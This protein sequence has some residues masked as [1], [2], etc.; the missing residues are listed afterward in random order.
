M[1]KSN[2]DILSLI[3]LLLC[4]NCFI[5][6]AVPIK[7]IK[8]YIKYFP[9][10]APVTDYYTIEIQRKDGLSAL[11]ELTPD[12]TQTDNDFRYAEETLSDNTINYKY[13]KGLKLYEAYKPYIPLDNGKITIEL[14]D[15]YYVAWIWNN[16]PAP[17]C[18]STETY[19]LFHIKIFPCEESAEYFFDT[20]ANYK[21]ADKT[22]SHKIYVKNTG[23]VDSTRNIFPNAGVDLYKIITGT[24]CSS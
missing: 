8:K 24:T 11:V 22:I 21:P 10:L 5:S 16:L 9:R 4:I 6:T 3:I 17:V 2:K 15:R 18:S 7:S 1:N 13:L 23:I 14:T 19:A 20:L 12:I